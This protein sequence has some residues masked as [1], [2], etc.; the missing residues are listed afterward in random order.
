MPN[1]DLA[2]GLSLETAPPDEVVTAFFR[3]FLPD[4]YFVNTPISRMRRHLQLI[5]ALPQTPLTIDFQRSAAEHF[6]E[7]TLCASDDDQPGLFSHVAG[8]LSALKLN[9]HTA[10]VHTLRDP[11]SIESGRRI[12]LDTLI[13]GAKLGGRDR[14]LSDQTQGRVRQALT[15]VLGGQIDATR[16]LVRSLRRAPPIF[17]EE[18]AVRLD[19]EATCRITLRARDQHALLFRITR[20]L[21]RQSFDIA[22]AQLNTSGGVATAIFWVTRSQGA[23]L[24]EAD[25]PALLETLR[26]ALE[27]DVLG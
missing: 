23:P 22:H 13:L 21:A 25:V 15:P 20:V 7:L 11:H 1:L 9:I 18:I 16:L 5:C 24:V 4:F 19:S 14:P 12:V 26:P 10:W 27:N 6:T 2:P 8:T 3:A 17:L